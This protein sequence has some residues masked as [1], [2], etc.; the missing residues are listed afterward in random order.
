M[1][2]IIG[3]FV[4]IYLW[5]LSLFVKAIPYLWHVVSFVFLWRPF[6]LAHHRLWTAD[7]NKYF[8]RL[9]YPLIRL[10]LLAIHLWFV[11]YWV[12]FFCSSMRVEQMDFPEKVFKPWPKIMVLQRRGLN[13]LQRLSDEMMKSGWYFLSAGP[14]GL[15]MFIFFR[16]RYGKLA[17]ETSRSSRRF[18]Y[19]E[20][21]HLK[22]LKKAKTNGQNYIGYNKDPFWLSWLDR[23]HIDCMGTTQIG[24]SAYVL[25]TLFRQDVE[26]G[27]PVIF[28]DAKGSLDNVA[29]VYRIVKS[30]GREADFRFFSLTM[31]ENSHTYNPLLTGNSV[32]VCDKVIS[33]MDWSAAQ[34][35]FKSLSQRALLCILTDFERERIDFTFENLLR[36][37]ENPAEKFKEIYQFMENRENRKN[38][39]NLRNEFTMICK[40]P[41]GFLLNT[42]KPDI[43]LKEVYDKNLIAY[44]SIDAQSYPYQA[45]RIGKMVTADIN[46]ICGLIESKLRRSEK[47][48]LCVFI[49]EFSVFGTESFGHAFAMG[50]SAGLCITIAHQSQGDLKSIG[51]DFAQRI[52]DLTSTKILLR[53]NDPETIELFC[54][55]AGTEQVDELTEQVQIAGMPDVSGRRFG[56]KKKVEG[57]RIFPTNIKDLQTGEAAIKCRSGHGIIC[58]C[59]WWVGLSNGDVK[60]PRLR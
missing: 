2:I 51:H 44:F 60:L 46:T 28:V 57:F 52:N 6:A 22:Y 55:S 21:K 36:A 10:G 56:T 18:V 17:G 12:F 54:K 11:S 30:A 25:L 19:D 58:L 5:T 8:V 29:A 43:D 14:L 45:S 59:P 42:V 39:E 37:L 31:L 35:Y 23:K 4:S 47:H 1:G 16:W 40:S 38:T 26:A 50:G 20:K 27:L 41:F 3:I 53:L 7:V 33:A 48:P 49:D 24:K 9:F 32:Q 13:N 34:P 15:G